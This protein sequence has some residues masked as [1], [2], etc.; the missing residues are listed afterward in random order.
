MTRK[1]EAVTSVEMDGVLR[2]SFAEMSNPS[3]LIVNQMPMFG[4][5]FK[6]PTPR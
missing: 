3:S 5:T 1:S 2:W 6:N 4:N